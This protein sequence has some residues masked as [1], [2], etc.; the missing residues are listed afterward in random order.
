L[1][2]QIAKLFDTQV[3]AVDRT[4]K[5]E[6]MRYLGA[7]HVIDYTQE[8]FTQNG[9]QYDLIFD[10]IT[11]RS[12]FNY[13]RA[14]CKNGTYVTVGGQT[15][16][17]LQVVCFQKLVGKPGMHMVGYKANKDVDYLVELF[18]AGK[19]KPVV[20]Q[21]F[22]LEETADAFRLYGQGRCK[23]KIVV[24]MEHADGA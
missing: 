17:I 11:N 4:E 12:I 9:R 13:K 10:V 3:T 20:D 16:R 22:P 24:T 8:D 21:Y 23:G 1:A 6:T 18:E 5:L 14:L 19:L 2:I 7:D 15:S